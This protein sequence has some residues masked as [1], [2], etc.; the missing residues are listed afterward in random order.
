MVQFFFF[1]IICSLYILMYTFL[2]PYYM[3]YCSLI[4]WA[5]FIRTSWYFESKIWQE[6]NNLYL[7]LYIYYIYTDICFT[8][9]NFF[10]SEYLL[11]YNQQI[12]WD[13]ESALKWLVINSKRKFRNKC[14]SLNWKKGNSL[15]LEII[16][17]F[18][19]G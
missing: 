14:V 7:P 1:F 9:H 11:I 12:K 10:F 3:K 4:C 2:F 13:E 8:L 18:F 15:Y 19:R 5:W 6:T 16:I 17:V